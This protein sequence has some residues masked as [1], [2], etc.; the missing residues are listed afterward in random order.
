M[1]EVTVLSV[2]PLRLEGTV[3]CCSGVM[4]EVAEGTLVSFPLILL[5]GAGGG[6]TRVMVLTILAGVSLET[7]FFVVVSVIGLKVAAVEML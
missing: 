7:L 4:G 5:G 3:S 2:S 1:A 6:G